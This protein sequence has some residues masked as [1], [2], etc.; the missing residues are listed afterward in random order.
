MTGSSVGQRS[1]AVRGAMKRLAHASH[2]MVKQVSPGLLLSLAAVA[3]V[4][5]ALI[6]LILYK[7]KSDMAEAL[8]VFRHDAE[9]EADRA[10]GEVGEKLL[11]IQQGLR[12]ITLL[13]GVRRITSDGENIGEDTKAS[14]QQLYNNLKSNVDI[15]EVY[16]V[17]VDLDPDR[18][19]AP[20]EPILMFDELIV[21]AAA[22][23]RE[24]GVLVEDEHTED[25]PEVEI[26]EYRAL[27]SQLAW[28]RE[29]FPTD[30]GFAGLDRPMISTQ[31]MITCDNTVFVLTRRDE[32]RSGIILSV[33]FYGMD[34]RLN[35]VVSAIVRTGALIGYL[36]ERN[37]ALLNT[38]YGYSAL[39]SA[40]GVERT[41][42]ADVTAGR[43]DP[44]LLFSATIT[45]G[46]DE[47][48]GD[49]GSKSELDA[50]GQW[51]LW[52]GRP[53]S[54][55]YSSAA[56]SSIKA[57]E[58]LS[59]AIAAVFTILSILGLLVLRL[60]VR[61]RTASEA[62]LAEALD[63][64]ETASRA[65][66]AFLANMSHEI[67]TPL[68][69]VLGM[70]QVLESL[71]LSSEAR[72]L[73]ETIRDSG[74]NLV[75]ILNDV[76]DLSKIEAGR[77][78][79]SPV[80]IDFRHIVR[81]VERLFGPAAASK[82]IDLSITVDASIPERLS[83]DATRM[84]QCLSNLVSNAI[85]FTETGSV[86][87]SALGRPL[88]DGA[89]TVEIRVTDTGVGI[90]G[91]A[92]AKLFEVF[93]QAD[94][95]TT[96]RFGGTGLGLAI[97]RRLARLMG[98][99]IAVASEVGKGST[100]TLT[101]LANAVEISTALTTP[102][103][104]APAVDFSNIDDLR[105]LVVDDNPLNRKVVRLLLTAHRAA[106]VE[107][108][109]G[110]EALAQLETSTFDLVLL[111]AHMPVMDGPT[112]IA[113]IRASPM[114]WSNL[115]VVALTADA[116]VGDREKYLAM[117]M[118]GYA[119]KPVNRI[120]LLTEMSKVLGD[121]RARGVERITSPSSNPEA[122]STGQP[123]ASL[124]DDDLDSILGMIDRAAG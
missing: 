107:A 29:N 74:N 122:A 34:G 1:V 69:G 64:A 8:A 67:R 55:F 17:P 11:L 4:S 42:L 80:D 101:F 6:A 22:R 53:N 61:R 124:A 5:A 62:T 52:A 60:Y 97:S 59:M 48:H 110:R 104:A 65:K 7:S 30:A 86:G 91:D 83:F 72:P 77:M 49:L 33:P 56:V 23:A 111:D 9:L 105:I 119:S 117:G 120:A 26:F 96:R 45:L 113:H 90:P 93:T 112:T 27:R 85:K 78:T 123:A 92:L 19:G 15:S 16:I 73:V 95:S 13:P 25:E 94:E 50:Q 102:Q 32:D 115:P 51:V 89:W 118:S 47:N 57:F 88:S 20:D 98:G 54:D 109:N 46:A 24:Q 40:P 10:A 76:L 71:N 106:I 21:N 121:R 103:T 108:E 58:S 81:R 39:S 38:A 3:V 75:H 87:V 84:Q 63:A 18:A 99:D 116:M 31:E 41:S 79:L 28:L 66:S 2:R 43:P 68:N 82:G 70:A 12:T 37:A 14:I 100:F 44:D 36:P 35:G 114:P